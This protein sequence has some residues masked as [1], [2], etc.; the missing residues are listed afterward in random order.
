MHRILVA[1]SEVTMRIIS[2]M[3]LMEER[4]DDL[5]RGKSSPCHG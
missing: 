1:H 5:L 4:Y 2:A 3:E